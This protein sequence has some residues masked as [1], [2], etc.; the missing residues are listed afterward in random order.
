ME[1]KSGT[2]DPRGLLFIAVLVAVWW[3]ATGF[4]KLVPEFLLPSPEDVWRSFVSLGFSGER[5]GALLGYR[6]SLWGHIAASALRLLGGFGIAVAVAVPVGILMASFRT[7]D[8]LLDPLIE[9]LRPIPPI[10]WTPLA[11]LWFGIGVPPIL[12]IIF[13]G[14]FWPVLLNT[15]LGVREVRTVLVRAGQ[16]LGASRLQIFARI[17]L[18]AA[19]PYVFTGLRSGLTVGW[20]M[21]VPAEMITA[22][23]GLGFLIMRA[24]EN[25]Q[26]A[27]VI[28]GIIAVALVGYLFQRAMARLERLRIFRTS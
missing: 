17:V 28:T 7:I 18:P 21:I 12:F 25:G 19:L 26:T 22:E 9:S 5:G 1:M 2:L 14:A 11:I 15:I 16:S 23:T 4:L 3:V 6:V 13:L 24:R 20:W 10:A 8:D 27:H